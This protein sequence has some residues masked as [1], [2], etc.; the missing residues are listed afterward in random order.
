MGALFSSAGSMGQAIGG[1]F[2]SPLQ[3]LLDDLQAWARG[4]NPWSQKFLTGNFRPAVIEGFTN[5]LPVTRGQLPAGLSGE[6]VRNGPNPKYIP[7]G[8]YH[9]FDGDGMIHGVRITS[10]GLVNYVSRWTRTDRFLLEEQAQR[11]LFLRLGEMHGRFGLLKFALSNICHWL[12]VTPRLPPRTDG[13]ANTSVHYHDG[14]LMALMEGNVPM[15][16]RLLMDG[17]LEERGW[18]HYGGKLQHNMTAHPKND[19]RTGE[20]IFFGYSVR[21]KPFV[22][23]AVVSAE[24]QLGPSVDVGIQRPVMMHDFAITPQW[25]ILMDHP[26]E[27]VP[28][29]LTEGE[30]IFHFQEQKPS[31]LGLLPRHA[32]PGDK[33]EWYDFATGFVFHTAAAWEEGDE[34]VLLACRSESIQL[35]DISRQEFKPCLHEYRINRQTGQT[36]ERDVCMDEQGVPVCCEFPTSHPQTTGLQPRYVYCAATTPED[37]EFT[38]CVKVDVANGYRLV[39]R[40]TYGAG[41][42]GGECT[43]VPREGATEEDDG[44]LLTF[45]YDASTDSSEFWVMDARTMSGDPIAVVEIPHRVPYGFHG[46]WVSEE[47]MKNQKPLVR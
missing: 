46:I 16:L 38:S 17:R 39:G 7:K 44:Y 14:T 11:P 5:N 12:Y 41:R 33:T 31:R 19:P 1:L 2:F 24:G 4:E 9:W 42:T 18:L 29:R 45:V 40:I 37:F 34:I 35:V 26:L 27:L 6:F 15:G 22:Q 13:T 32:Q 30:F 20:M 3:R 28:K 43:F 23:H 25:S 10:E 36:S 21:D 8:G 47:Q